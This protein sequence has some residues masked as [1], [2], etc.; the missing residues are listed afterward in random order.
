MNL[1]RFIGEFSSF[2][3]RSVFIRWELRQTRYRI[4]RQVYE[5]GINSLPIILTV[6]AFVGLVSIVQT[7][8]QVAGTMPRYILGATVSRMVMIEL[9]PILTA[10]MV[11][12]RCASSM[13]AEI[14]TMRVTEQLDALEIM[15]I[16]PYRFLSLPRI[17]G[18]F[19]ALPVLTVIAE[20]DA[21]AVS[22][23]YAHYFLD[24]PFGVFNYGLTHFFFTRD[25][26]GGLFK[27]LFFSVV[28]ATSGCYFG[29]KVKGGAREVGR[30]ATYAVVTASLLVLVVDFL[31][32]LVIFG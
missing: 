18:M 17:V 10:L 19:I 8:Y 9:G 6:A 30:A 24:V 21:L 3:F 29:F 14:G 23:A 28:I 15:A 22:G 12:G 27:S 11:S 25:F 26:F 13:A 16:D 4:I 32:A 2:F 1:F 20:F 7:S 31:V 5:V